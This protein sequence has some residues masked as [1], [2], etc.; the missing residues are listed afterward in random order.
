MRSVRIIEKRMIQCMSYFVQIQTLLCI[1]ANYLRARYVRGFIVRGVSFAS[2][3]ITAPA[4]VVGHR[5]SARERSMNQ[6]KYPSRGVSRDRAPR[7]R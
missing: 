7:Q 5:Q 4:L 2:D 6:I 3:L 1:I